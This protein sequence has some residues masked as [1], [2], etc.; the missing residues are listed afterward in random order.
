LLTTDLPALET[1]AFIE[2]HIPCRPSRILEVGCGHG[3]VAARLQSNGHEVIAIDSDPEAV[4]RARERGVDA[5]VASWPDFDAAPFDVVLFTRSLHHIKPLREAVKRAKQVLKKGGRVLVEDFAFEEIDT[6]WRDWLYSHLGRLDTA[7]LL[8]RPGD[9]LAEN[10]LKH[11]GSDDACHCDRDHELHTAPAMLTCLRE[12][13][14]RVDEMTAPY[15]YRYVGAILE[16]TERGYAEGAKVL[17]LEKRFAE[18]NGVPLIGRRFAAHDVR[19]P[20]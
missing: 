2:A 1:E 10:L 12:H 6:L 16:D 3:G 14:S 20:E 15:L 7:G 8:R 17:E 5:R 13:F 18:T 19:P 4:A 9:G 11:H